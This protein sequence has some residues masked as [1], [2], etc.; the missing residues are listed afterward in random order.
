L[1]TWENL[2]EKEK[3]RRT[4]LGPCVRKRTQKRPGRR[5]NATETFASKTNLTSGKN[6]TQK[7]GEGE[8]EGNRNRRAS[9]TQSMESSRKGEGGDHTSL[10]RAVVYSSKRGGLKGGGGKK[11]A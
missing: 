2:G 6:F 4:T 5:V 11:D 10:S 9:C 1:S 8:K 3:L 7:K